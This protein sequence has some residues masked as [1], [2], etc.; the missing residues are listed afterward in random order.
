MVA[1]GATALLRRALGGR[2]H[3]FPRI[4]AELNANA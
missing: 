3:Q 1:L 2:V 4:S